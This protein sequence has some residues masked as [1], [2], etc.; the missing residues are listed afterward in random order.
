VAL[1]LLSAFSPRRAGQPVFV[2]G[3]LL[4]A[5]GLVTAV[6]CLLN[7]RDAP[8]DRPATLGLYRLSRNPQSVGLGLVGLGTCLC[9]GSWLALLLLA[10]VARIFHER[11]LAEEHA[12]LQQY[13]HS[14]CQYV[15]RV[16][17][18]LTFF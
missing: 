10:I 8:P 2:L 9:V 4:Y 7:F 13:G 15:E 17:R 11:V 14:Y 16:P 3:T 5:I 1:L 18:Y 6:I 12:C